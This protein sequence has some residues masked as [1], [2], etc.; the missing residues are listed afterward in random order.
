[1]RTRSLRRFTANDEAAFSGVRRGRIMETERHV[2]VVGVDDDDIWRMEVIDED[3][4]VV[5]SRP[6]TGMDSA[7]IAAESVGNALLNV[8]A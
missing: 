8:G 5:Y 4:E 3:A 6:F 2:V 7:L 1:M